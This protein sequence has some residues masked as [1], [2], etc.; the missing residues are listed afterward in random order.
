M[1][2][3]KA[4]DF[5]LVDNKT[6]EKKSHRLALKDG[7]ESFLETKHFATCQKTI[8]AYQRDF[9]EKSYWLFYF[10]SLIVWMAIKFGVM[11]PEI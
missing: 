2:L 4:S 5:Y 9:H 11:S 8:A 10:D 3:I 7:H 1:R 6:G